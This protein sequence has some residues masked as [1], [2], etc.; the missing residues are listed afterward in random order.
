MGGGQHSRE[1]GRNGSIAVRTVSSACYSRFAMGALGL[2]TIGQGS[3][4]PQRRLSTAIGISRSGGS[5]PAASIWT[6]TAPS[7]TTM[8]VREHARFPW[9]V[10]E[11]SRHPSEVVVRPDRSRGESYSWAT[12]P[13]YGPYDSVMQLG[14][15][16]ELL[17]AG[18][19]L[20]DRPRPQVG[21]QRPC[22]STRP[23]DTRSGKPPPHARMAGAS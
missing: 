14:P 3:R 8:L 12:A 23:M 10:D 15:L 4:N 5:S 16:P 20:P 6:A 13:R 18:D 9:L 21:H 7:S 19:P 11:G 1:P 17:L 22:P 2:H